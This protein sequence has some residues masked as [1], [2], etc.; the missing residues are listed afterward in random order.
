MTRDQYTIN[1][2]AILVAWTLQNVER[3]TL[4]NE[5]LSPESKEL[6]LNTVCETIKNSGA[7]I[8][9]ELFRADFTERLTSQL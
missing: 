4:R 6:F 9:L 5:F 3:D 2:S 1:T 7:D 8:N